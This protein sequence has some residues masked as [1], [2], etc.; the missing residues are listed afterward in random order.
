MAQKIRDILPDDYK[1]IENLVTFEIK[2]KKWKPQQ[3]PC[4]LCIICTDRIGFLYKK[5]LI[6][7]KKDV[8]AFKALCSQSM[9]IYN[10][11]SIHK[12][13]SSSFTFSVNCRYVIGKWFLGNLLRLKVDMKATLMN[14]SYA[15]WSFFVSLLVC[16]FVRL[17]V[18]F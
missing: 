12:N 1:N 3:I 16:L 10:Y 11:I 13:I 18:C 2:I 14:S 5:S 7:F 8:K 4:R 15:L 17:F 9:Y 6:I